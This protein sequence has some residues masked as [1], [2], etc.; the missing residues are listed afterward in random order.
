MLFFVMILA[1]VQLDPATGLWF[2]PYASRTQYLSRD[3]AH[4]LM[5]DVERAFKENPALADEVCAAYLAAPE[6]QGAESH[7]P[8]VRQFRAMFA[9]TCTGRQAKTRQQVENTRQATAVISDLQTA[10]DEEERPILNW[11]REQREKRARELV[12]I[13]DD[14]GGQALRPALQAIA[15]SPSYTFAIHS[16]LALP[17]ERLTDGKIGSNRAHT[18]AFLDQLYRSRASSPEWQAGLPAVLLFEGKLD[19]ARKAA[20]DWYAAAPRER[21]SFARTMLSVIDRALGREGA[22]DKVAAGCVPPASWKKENPEGDSADYCRQATAMLVINA[23]DVQQEK[24]PHALVDAAFD[25]ERMYFKDNWPY[26]LAL[27][28]KAGFADPVAAQKHFYDMLADPDIPGG[29]QIDAVHD[30]AKIAAVRDASRVAPLVDCWIKLQGI[31][32]APASPEMWK[33]F[34][35]MTAPGQKN[36]ACLSGEANTWCI[37]HALAMRRDAALKTKNWNLLRHT[38]EKMASIVV[39]SGGNPTPVRSELIDLAEHELNAGRRAQAVQIMSF[40]KSQPEDQYASSQLARLGDAVPA[41]AAQPWPSPVSVEVASECP[42]TENFTR[43]AP[44]PRRRGEWCCAAR[45]RRS[46]PCSA[47]RGR[48]A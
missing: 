8:S 3:P 44:P 46:S 14:G 9:M 25:L 17:N 22:F 20:D 7:D 4:P 26:R 42:P 1:A 37:F 28:A 43:G 24:A 32:I 5:G 15:L 33:R 40:L 48:P 2:P 35:T 36:A 23:L 12:T 29:A 18:A 31:D 27:V 16:L 41:G 11:T 45:R 21:A 19:D 47:R 39:S 34:A 13:V 38:I 30:L 6:P 10:F